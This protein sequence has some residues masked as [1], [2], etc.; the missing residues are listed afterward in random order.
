SMDVIETR[1][2]IAGFSLLNGVAAGSYGFSIIKLQDWDQ[3]EADSLSVGTTIQKLFGLA[4][5]FK[6]A[7]IIYFT[8]PSISGFG[9]SSGFEV[10]LQSTGGEDWIS[11]NGVKD[12]FLG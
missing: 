4:A 10:Q 12:Q 1:M 7:E 11:I 5:G 3:R 8:P 6:D 2:N 9:T